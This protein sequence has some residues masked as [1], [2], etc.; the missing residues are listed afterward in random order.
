MKDVIHFAGGSAHCR[1]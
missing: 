1:W